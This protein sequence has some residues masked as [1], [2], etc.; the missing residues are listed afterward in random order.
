[1]MRKLTFTITGV[2]CGLVISGLAYWQMQSHEPF[3]WTGVVGAVLFG[4]IGL[5][6]SFTDPSKAKPRP[7]KVDDGVEKPKPPAWGYI[8]LVACLG[9]MV[10]TK[11]GAIWGGIGGG[12]GMGCLGI[13]ANQKLPVAAR[14]GI[15]TAITVALW[16]VV[17]LLIMSLR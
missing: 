12:L 10:L 13:C 9:I 16:V 6:A 7:A 4:I 17:F 5:V 14:V 8:F 3:L 2:I 1:M 11:G 15:C